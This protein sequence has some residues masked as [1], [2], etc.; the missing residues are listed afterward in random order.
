MQKYAC[1]AE[2]STKVIRGYFFMFT[3]YRCQGSPR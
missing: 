2:I 1:I 3:R